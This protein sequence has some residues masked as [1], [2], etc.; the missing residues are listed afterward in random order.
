MNLLYIRFHGK[1]SMYGSNYSDE[2]LNIWAEK[3]K[4]SK[5]KLVWVLSLQKLS[6]TYE[7][8]WKKRVA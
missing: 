1:G 7:L 3:I 2:E 8:D 6:N 4:D 5:A